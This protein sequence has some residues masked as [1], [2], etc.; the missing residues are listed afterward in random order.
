MK[1][2]YLIKAIQVVYPNGVHDKIVLQTPVMVDDLEKFRTEQR[3]L[4]NCSAVNLTY[5]EKDERKTSQST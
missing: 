1:N 5:T 4:H 2:K 3:K